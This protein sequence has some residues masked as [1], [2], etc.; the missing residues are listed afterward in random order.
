MVG[1]GMKFNIPLGV[2]IDNDKMTEAYTNTQGSVTSDGLNIG[3]ASGIGNK[4]N[5]YLNPDFS[6]PLDL[7]P[8]NKIKVGA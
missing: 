6:M 7:G 1:N 5:V 2:N 3:S 8:F 4:I